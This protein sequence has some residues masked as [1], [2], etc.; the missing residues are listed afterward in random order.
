MLLPIRKPCRH[1]AGPRTAAPL[2]ALAL[3]A[4]LGACAGMP[5]PNSP[6]AS[7]SLTETRPS[8]PSR[9]ELVRWQ[10]ADGSNRPLPQADGGEPVVLE[11][12]AGIDAEQGTVSGNTGCNRLRGSY[13]KTASGMRF[14]GLASTRMA[15]PPP[16]MAIESALLQAFREPLTTVA[17]Q[18]SS[19]SGGRQI[20][21][22]TAS[23]DLLHFA[24][25]EGVGRRADKLDDNLD[26]RQ[27]KPP[28]NALPPGEKRVHVDG[29]RVACADAPQQICHRVRYD[30]SDEW[31]LWRGPIE[32]LD[33]EQGVAYTLRVRE[34]RAVGQG[35]GDTIRW[36]VLEVERRSPVR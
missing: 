4:L 27:G 26:D 3:S 19:G 28:A 6:S 29:Q 21:W 25:R 35:G 11:F 24:E 5:A 17:S 1:R 7:P 16:R 18:P 31:Q 9:W 33:F 34:S 30:G 15:C 13:G 20:I 8:G 23:G 10:Q 36:E 22:K 2:A 32:G 12:N 14:D